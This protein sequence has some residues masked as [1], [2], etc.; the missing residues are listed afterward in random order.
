MDAE[1]V[2]QTE[3][4]L[5]LGGIEKPAVVAGSS[6]LG[7]WKPRAVGVIGIPLEDEAEAEGCMGVEALPAAVP[8]KAPSAWAGASIDP[9]NELGER[10]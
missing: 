9:G 6:R 2:V 3:A 4:L 8:G 7:A 5:S 1:A 10:A